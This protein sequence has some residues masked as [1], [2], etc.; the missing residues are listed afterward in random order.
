MNLCVNCHAENEGSS[1]PL[2]ADCTACHEAQLV[3]NEGRGAKG[4]EGEPGVMFASGITCQMC[5]TGVE[6]GVYRPSAKSCTDCHD[7]SYVEVLEDWSQEIKA[8][9]GRLS[10]LRA[11]VE[12][13]LLAA[14]AKK[15]ST[16]AG[17]ELYTKAL[18][19]LNLVKDDG[20]HG[21]HNN[22]YVQDI[23]KSVETDLNQV[24]ADLRSKW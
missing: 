22:D 23:L 3:I 18:Y 12:K 16:E 14:D 8:R 2:I 17:W 20:T 13:T 15:R 19:N 21:V 9:L 7:A 6:E 24:L 4:V 11:D 10:L 1:A 5:H